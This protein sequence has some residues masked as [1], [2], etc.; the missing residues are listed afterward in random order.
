MRR[1]NAAFIIISHAPCFYPFLKKLGN[2]QCESRVCTVLD[3]VYTT[4][5]AVCG[6]QSVFIDTEWLRACVFNIR[7]HFVSYLVGHVLSNVKL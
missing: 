6:E 7:M 1:G 4:H 3:G 5:L 2:I